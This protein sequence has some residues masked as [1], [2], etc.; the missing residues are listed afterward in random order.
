MENNENDFLAIWIV[1]SSYIFEILD[2]YFR[3]GIQNILNHSKGSFA[4]SRC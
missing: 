3:I 1:E 4:V 2:M